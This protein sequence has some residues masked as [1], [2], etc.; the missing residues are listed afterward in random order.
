MFAWVERADVQ[1]VLAIGKV[2]FV[3]DFLLTFADWKMFYIC[4]GG[5]LT[6]DYNGNRVQVGI[7]SFG[8][9]TSCVQGYP[10]VFTKVANFLSWIE[11]KTDLVIA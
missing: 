9:Q 8:S 2:F 1:L 5:P 3:V 11:S 6:I 7:V 10:V 4:S